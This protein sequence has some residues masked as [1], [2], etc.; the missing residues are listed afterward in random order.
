MP[1]PKSHLVAVAAALLILACGTKDKPQVDTTTPS[2]T[3]APP[4]SSAGSTS[5]TADSMVLVRGSLTSA[6]STELVVKTDSASVTVSTPQPV[7]IFARGPSDLSHVAP[8]SFVG[9]T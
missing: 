8:N 4:P 6:T 3:P 9:V 1:V 7:Q 5:P 2:A